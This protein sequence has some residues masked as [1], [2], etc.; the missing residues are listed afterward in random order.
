[1]HDRLLK[2]AL[3]ERKRMKNTRWQW[4]RSRAGPLIASVALVCSGPA[5]TAQPI[6]SDGPQPSAENAAVA[7]VAGGCFWCMEPP[8]EK[9]DGVISVVSGYTGGDQVDPSYQQV[10]SGRTNYMEAVQITYDPAIIGYHQLLRVFWK[11][12]DPT[13]DGGQFADRGAHYRTAIFVH[14]DYER[15]VAEAS[16]AG[17]VDSGIFGNEIVTEIRPATAFYPAEGYHQD[18]YKK[19]PT[20][21]Y[22][23]RRGSGR[24]GF[25]E[26]TWDE[27]D[28]SATLGFVKPPDPLLKSHL[29][30][31]QFQVTQHDGTERPYANTYWD[32]KGEGIYVDIV[33]GE[34]LFSS[35]DKFKSGTGWPSFTRPMDDEVLA[36]DVDYKIGV[37]RM[38]I[39][40]KLADS[41]LGHVFSDGPAPT[42]LRY[43]MNSASLRF[44]SKKQMEPLGYGSWLASLE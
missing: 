21:Y 11:G 16:R 34:P 10:S 27:Q 19:N 14:N 42:G 8:F 22:A 30:P 2:A 26:R 36:E 29:D 25:L 17:L 4:P 1:M 7:I 13:D 41:H 37:P 40:S 24:T 9:L 43:C 33:S 38:E 35:A 32:H 6:T 44:V 3:R 28:L 5:D 20:H 15:Q 23:Y 18:Y 31:L 39:R 12:I